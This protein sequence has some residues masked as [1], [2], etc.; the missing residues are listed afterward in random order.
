MNG[1]KWVVSQLDGN[2]SYNPDNYLYY[3]Y[4]KLQKLLLLWLLL[5]FSDKKSNNNNNNNNNS[6]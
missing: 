3:K 2:G 1:M 5:F 6:R 4:Q